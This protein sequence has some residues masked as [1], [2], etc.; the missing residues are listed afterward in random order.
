MMDINVVLN[1]FWQKLADS[2]AYRAWT[3]DVPSSDN[4]VKESLDRNAHWEFFLNCYQNL[5]FH[6][7]SYSAS[8]YVSL[9]LG[10]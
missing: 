5:K 10:E 2:V 7:S 3:I 8:I 1:G 4:E 6:N 9:A